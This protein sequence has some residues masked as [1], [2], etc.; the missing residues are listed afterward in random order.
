MPALTPRFDQFQ[1]RHL[2]PDADATAAM[3]KTI[4]TSSLDELID[5]TVPANIRDYKAL[6]RFFCG[7]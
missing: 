4:G 6:K 2:G 7:K 1:D 5:Q 3:L